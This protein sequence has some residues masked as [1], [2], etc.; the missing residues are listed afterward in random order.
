MKISSLLLITLLTFNSGFN[1]HVQTRRH[2][3]VCVWVLFPEGSVILINV[4][5]SS[6][7]FSLG[8]NENESAHF[9]IK[10]CW[11]RPSK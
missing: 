6:E 3:D 7:Y 11:F 2:T 8:M 10:M 5:V 4:N 9:G 1:K